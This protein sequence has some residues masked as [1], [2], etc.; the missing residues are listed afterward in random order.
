MD[1]ND[2]LQLIRIIPFSQLWV[3][4]AGVFAGAGI[5]IGV[6]GSLSAIRKFLQV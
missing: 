4:V 5:L 1:T 3:P 2:T 6:G